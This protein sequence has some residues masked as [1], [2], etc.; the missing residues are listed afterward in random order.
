MKI[1]KLIKK[2]GTLE[3]FQKNNFKKKKLKNCNL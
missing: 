1:N 3:D 2:V